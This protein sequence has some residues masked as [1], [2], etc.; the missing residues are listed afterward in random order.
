MEE[1]LENPQKASLV[2]D[3]EYA[4]PLCTAIQIVL[5]GLLARWGIR[6]AAV[7]GHSSGMFR[8]SN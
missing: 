3:A 8:W 1:I 7:V 6:P 4:Q 5:V 2:N